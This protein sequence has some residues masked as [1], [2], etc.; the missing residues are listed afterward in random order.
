MRTSV[1]ASQDIS[2][3]IQ[4]FLVVSIFVFVAGALYV[5]Y[6]ILPAKSLTMLSGLVAGLVILTVVF[7]WQPRIAMPLIIVSIFFS[8]DIVVA[9]I[10]GRDVNLRVEDFLLVAA[11]LSLIIRYAALRE[12]FSISTPLDKPIIAYCA[13]GLVSTLV[14]AYL[15]NVSALRGFFFFL[16]R[17]EYFVLFYFIYYCLE[18]E[19]EIKLAIHLVFVCILIVS[20]YDAY[21]RLTTP[22]AVQSWRGYSLPG[23][24]ERIADYGELL[25]MV[26]PIMI[27]VAVEGKSF[28]YKIFAIVAFPF[29]MYLLLDSLRRSAF[30]GVAVAFLF[31]VLYRYRGLSIPLA[32]ASFYFAARLPQNILRRITFLWEEIVHY[33]QAG[34]S[35]PL[36]VHGALEALRKF[37]YRPLIGEGLGTYKL[38]VAIS[39]NQ[40][41]LFLSEIGIL[42]IAVFFW[43]IYSC[44]RLCWQGMKEAVNALH[45][46]YCIGFLA[47]L[48]GWLVM[49]LAVISFST[50]R[51]MGFFMTMTAILVA[52]NKQMHES[53]NPENYKR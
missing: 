44:S 9:Q 45:R 32:C 5:G 41:A 40:Y 3:A 37:L 10:P 30:V 51:P 19:R 24:K 48:L 29:G 47:G 53:F 17:V 33:P 46:G 39:H 12:R 35:F 1:T 18:G 20:I 43:L 21:M 13:V 34:G 15:G 2:R 7:A 25:V 14:G 6:Q 31:L 22:V 36:R 4:I 38:N 8:P 42:G 27:A 16:K 50:I 23:T 49:N 52:I 28:F 11:L 26:L